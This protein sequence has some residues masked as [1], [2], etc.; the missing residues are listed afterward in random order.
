MGKRGGVEMNLKHRVQVLETKFD[1]HLVTLKLKDGSVHQMP[2]AALWKTVFETTKAWS[3]FHLSVPEEARV[4]GVVPK[5]VVK[6]VPLLQTILDTT[7]DD[8]DG[9]AVNLIQ[10]LCAGPHRADSQIGIEQR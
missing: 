2:E 3:T 1:P 5:E 8:A 6:A 10:N 4:F 9:Y 7:H